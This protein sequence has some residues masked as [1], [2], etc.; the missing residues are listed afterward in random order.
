MK[1]KY[2]LRGMGI[3]IVLTTVLFMILIF[4]HGSDTESTPDLNTESKTVAQYEHSTQ[5]LLQSDPDEEK[6]SVSTE[7]DEKQEDHPASAKS[8]TSKKQ[9]EKKKETPQKESKTE[10]KTQKEKQET[11]QKTPQAE[12]ETKQDEK[13]RFEIS[14]GEFS[15]TVSQ[16]L[17]DAGLVDDAAA[18][19]RF[20]I[21]QDYDNAILPGV[22]EIP[23]DSTYDEIAALLTL[24]A[25]EN[26]SVDH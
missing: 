15:D 20:L 9:Q 13:V 19:N 11:G 12:S 22:Y 24:K 2:Y 3:G 25:E 14:S 4:M 26:Q 7:Q 10:K 18:F 5:E 16:K 1:L 21:E 6:S 23:R 8:D 17:Q